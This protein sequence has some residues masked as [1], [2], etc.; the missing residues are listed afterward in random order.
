MKTQLILLSA[1]ILPGV[2]LGQGL[3]KKAIDDFENFSNP[4]VIEKVEGKK[5]ITVDAQRQMAENYKLTG[6]YAMAESMYAKI[7]NSTEKTEED[8]Y[9]YSQILKMNGK[10]T[11][12]RYHMNIF[13]LLKTNDIRAKL[14]SENT[15]YAADLLKDNGQFKIKN[16]EANSAQQDFGVTYYKDNVVFTSSRCNNLSATLHHWTSGNLPYLDLYLGKIDD[17]NEICKTKKLAKFNKKYH[18]GP[19]TYSKDGNIVM[20]TEDNYSAKSSDG[21]RKLVIMEAKFKDGKWGEK[22]PFPLNNK[23]Y[24]VGHPSLS[25]DGNTLYFSSDMPGGKGGVDIYRATRNADGTWGNAENLG[26]KINTEG[27]EMFPFIH[28]NGFLFFSSDGRPGLG[29]LDVFAT[30]IKN[31][32]ISKVINVGA[33]VNGSKDDFTFV[34][35]SEKTKG[36]FAS[37][38]EGGKGW[39]DIYSFDLIVPFKFNKTIIGTAKDKEGNILA[40]TKVNLY[41]ASGNVINTVLTTENAIYSFDVDDNGT[42]N[43]VGTKDKYS[44]GNNSVNITEESQIVISNVVL[45][46]TPDLALLALITDAVSMEPLEGVKATLT[47]VLNDKTVGDY[48]TPETGDFKTPLGGNKIGDKIVYKLKLE[49]QGYLSKE[50]VFSYVI[51]KPGEIKMHETLDLSMARLKVG[52]DLAKMVDLKSIYFDLGK[53]NIRKDA[54]TELDKIVKIMNEYPNMVVELGAHTD[55]RGTAAANEKLSQKRATSSAEYIKKMIVNPERIYGKGY[56][57]SKLLNGCACEG[58]VKTTYTEEQHQENRR[59]EFIIVKYE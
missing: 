43:L 6:N 24:S 21:F 47:D 39:D 53:W 54:A 4:K 25:A 1:F 38:R 8:I 30:Q 57:E 49:K 3:A 29:G 2:V 23:E 10:Y 9:A 32:K 55:C 27:N 16:L 58:K 17:K 36:Y 37:N 45:E 42:Y 18:E 5:K 22:I 41:D 35:N 34:L 19:A 15:T 40:N 13:S 11:E 31:N 7:V 59:T 20:Y 33:P 28:E 14:F 12:A 56:G 50:V 26:D 46:K 48:N 44:D 52:G 51:V